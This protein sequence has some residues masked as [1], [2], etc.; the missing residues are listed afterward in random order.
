MTMTRQDMKR[1]D[2]QRLKTRQDT[3]RQEKISKTRQENT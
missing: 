2:V 1:Q 3:E